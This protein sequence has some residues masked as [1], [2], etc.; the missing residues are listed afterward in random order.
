[1]TWVLVG[2]VFGEI[3]LLLPAI[4][5]GLMKEI[6]NSLQTDE[7]WTFAPALSNLTISLFLSP[8][9]ASGPASEAA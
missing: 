2:Y 9:S 8:I 6:K 5:C 1:V 7:T 3:S 4:S